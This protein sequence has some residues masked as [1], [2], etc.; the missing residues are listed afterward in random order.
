MSGS[1]GNLD[2]LSSGN[3]RLAQPPEPWASLPQSSASKS[4][5]RWAELGSQAERLADPSLVA[6]AGPGSRSA[7]LRLVASAA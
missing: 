6:K 2:A 7:S 1:H 5:A 3:E 4:A